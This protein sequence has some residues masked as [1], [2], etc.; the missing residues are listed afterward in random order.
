MLALGFTG[1]HA[2]RAVSV[3]IYW[4][5]NRDEPIQGWMT[6]GFVAHSYH[7]PAHILYQA[8]GLPHRPPDR[9]P[10]RAIAEAQH[11]SID[12]VRAALQNAIVHA[13]PPYPPPPPPDDGGTL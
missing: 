2:V 9:R 13:R 1:Y 10:L 7:V 11:R 6:V 5:D 12:A 4:N 8:I 3:A